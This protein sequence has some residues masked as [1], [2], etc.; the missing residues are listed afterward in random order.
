MDVSADNFDLSPEQ[1]ARLAGL[2][3]T[4]GKSL[5]E[6]LDDVLATYQPPRVQ[7]GSGSGQSFFDAASKHGLIGSIRGTPPDLST[8]KSY[9][10]GFGECR[11][12]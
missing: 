7:N 6:V 1:F 5:P 3:K 2:A 8:N 11:Q 4:T 9:L 10:E 12:T